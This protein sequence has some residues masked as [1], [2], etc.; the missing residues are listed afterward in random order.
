MCGE[1]WLEQRKRPRFFPRKGTNCFQKPR[2]ELVLAPLITALPHTCPSLLLATW[3]PASPVVV[4]DGLRA[5]FVDSVTTLHFL[6]ENPGRILIRGIC[7]E[8]R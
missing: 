6:S 2:P 5:M 8:K 3:S 7:W 1:A 4:S